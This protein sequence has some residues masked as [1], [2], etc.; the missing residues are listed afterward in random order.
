MFSIGWLGQKNY[1]ALA[2]VANNNMGF[3]MQKGTQPNYNCIHRACTCSY[4]RGGINVSPYT[5][6]NNSL[7]TAITIAVTAMSVNEDDGVL[8]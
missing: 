6:C 4:S 8:R 7:F 2:T 5:V 3:G 1:I